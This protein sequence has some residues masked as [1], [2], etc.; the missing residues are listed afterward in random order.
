MWFWI[1]GWFLVTL[2]AVG[3]ALVIYLIFTVPRLQSSANWFVL[4]LALADL[5][6]ALAFFPPL[7]G[8]NFLYTMD[9]SH[10]GL[11]FKI[12]F[13]L[14][15]CLKHQS[16]RHDVGP[17]L[18]HFTTAALHDPDEQT[19]HLGPCH[20]GV[21]NT[22]SSL[23]AARRLHIPEQPFLHAVRRVFPCGHFSD[24]TLG[25]FRG[26]HPPPSLSVL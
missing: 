6:A 1:S 15:Y 14:M 18:C 12:S 20:R 5:F 3:N 23:L 24:L 11:F 2:A 4:S 25:G 8:A 19:S 10:A 7:F 9:T 17:L 13:T 21:D 26:S 16:L 22:I